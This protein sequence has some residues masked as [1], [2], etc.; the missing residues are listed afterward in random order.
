MIWTAKERPAH[1]LATKPSDPQHTQAPEV[2]TIELAAKSPR[3]TAAEY[4][5]AMWSSWQ[6]AGSILDQLG[7]AE[8]VRVFRSHGPFTANLHHWA[9][10]AGVTV[11][12]ESAGIPEGIPQ[13]YRGAIPNGRDGMSWSDSFTYALRYAVDADG[14]LF[15]CDFHAADFLARI[16]YTSEDKPGDDH[17]EWIMSPTGQAT[18]WSPPWLT[19]PTPESVAADHERMKSD[20]TRLS[21]TDG[22]APLPMR[23]RKVGTDE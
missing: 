3:E 14:Q 6:P 17:Y 10:Y 20:F 11:S 8:A 1:A 15:T 18:L 19:N 22:E 16:R 7:P 4:L 5:V 9:N 2:G 12:F 21:W 13:L 23:P